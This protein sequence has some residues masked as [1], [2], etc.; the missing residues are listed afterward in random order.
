[1]AKQDRWF[2]PTNTDNLKMMVAQG[3]ITS[4]DGFSP[5]KYY[6]DELK[7]YP[8]YIPLF[9]NT[10]PSKTLKLVVSEAKGMTACL[11]EI[12]LTAIKN[13]E[14]TESAFLKLLAPLPLSCIKQIIFKSKKDKDNLENEQKVSSNFILAGLKLHYGKPG[15]KLFVTTD[16]LDGIDANIETKKLDMLDSVLPP[17]VNYPKVYAF[18]G[19]LAN[20]LY[21]TK[22]GKKSNELYKN[23]LSNKGE[24]IKTNILAVYRYFFADIQNSE[25]SLQTM[26][27][28]LIDKSINH[29]DFKNNIIELLEGDTWDAKLKER[30]VELAQKLR[31][32]EGNDRPVS[33]RFEQAKKPLERLL[34]MLFHKENTDGMWDYHLDLLS[35]EDYLLFALLFGIRDK[36]IK[37]PKS[38]RLYQELQNFISFKMAEFA[39]ENHKNSGSSDFLIFKKPKAPKTIYSLIEKINKKTLKELGLSFCINTIMEGDYQQKSGKA[40]YS[41]FIEP[42]YEIIE[43]KFFKTMSKK[44]IDDQQ[45][46]KLIKNK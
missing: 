19:L 18:G 20:L 4:L 22:N 43:D 46:N 1:M 29:D 15:E 33:A 31:E 23:F 32:F 6:C 3:L 38:L 36:F 39:H 5:E 14:K 13:I 17:Q 27:N 41:R 37:I 42:K 2:L 26:Y 24:K 25:D 44:N 40:I 11:I 16:T 12:N 28:A 9:K 45:Y 34:L 10:I 21:F 35:E 8:G 30:T 7:N